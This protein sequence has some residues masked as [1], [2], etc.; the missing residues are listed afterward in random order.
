M[1]FLKPKSTEKESK[2]TTKVIATLTTAIRLR[3]KEKL[4]PDFFWDLVLEMRLAI[5]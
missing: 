5:N 4:K 3:S 1:A 2:I